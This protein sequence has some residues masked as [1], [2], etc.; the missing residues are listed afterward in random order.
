MVILARSVDSPRG[1]QGVHQLCE[2]ASDL[3]SGRA[4]A[5]HH[6]VEAAVALVRWGLRILQQTTQ[7]ATKSFGVGDRVERES[8]LGRARHAE[9]V[10]SGA[11]RHDQVRTRSRCG[12]RTV[13]RP[14]RT[15]RR[16]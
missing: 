1:V 16:R 3:D 2:R 4:A 15:G 10:R 8:V 13:A 14:V 6:D 11:R 9:E 12:R 7:V 5:D